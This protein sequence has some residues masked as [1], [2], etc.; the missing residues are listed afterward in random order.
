MLYKSRLEL[1]RLLL[2]DFDAR[3]PGIYAQPCLVTAVI[4]GRARWHVPDFLPAVPPGWRGWRTSSL[5]A[6]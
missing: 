1:A 3:V 5:L 6:C 2:T 4:G